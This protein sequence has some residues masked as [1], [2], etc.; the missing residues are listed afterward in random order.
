MFIDDLNG[1]KII[2]KRIANILRC[3]GFN[4]VELNNSEDYQT[5]KAYDILLNNSIKVEVKEDK[6]A[7]KTGNFAIEF[8]CYKKPSGITTTEAILYIYVIDDIA[9]LFRTID[10]KNAI[11]NKDYFRIVKGGDYAA[12]LMYLFK[13]DIIL[14][15]SIK[16]IEL[17]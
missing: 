5:L 15:L 6:L 1:A 12:S 11:K 2:E 14:K 17:N 3:I 4:S 9:Y 13:L 16:K 7:T 8:E 10:L